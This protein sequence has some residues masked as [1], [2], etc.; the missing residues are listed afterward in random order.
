MAVACVLAQA[1]VRRQHN[2]QVRVPKEA[3]SYRYRTGWVRCTGPQGILG[4]RYPEEKDAADTRGGKLASVDEC[5]IGR[6]A[7]LAGHRLDGFPAVDSRH[8]EDRLDEGCRIESG[9]THQ[10]PHGAAPAAAAGPVAGRGV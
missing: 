3:E 8:D 10:A 1:H 2:R 5:E 9:L 4:V 6:H 7:G